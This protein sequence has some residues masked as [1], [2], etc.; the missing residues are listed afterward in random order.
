M[1]FRKYWFGRISGI[2]LFA[3]MMALFAVPASADSVLYPN[4]AGTGEM[5]AASIS[6]PDATADSFI[7]SGASKLTRVTFDAVI[8]RV[9]GSD[10]LESLDWAIGSDAFLS[11]LGSGSFSLF[12]T[13]L[14]PYATFTTQVIG[15]PV[16]YWDFYQEYFD[17]TGVTLDAGT[18]W[19]TLKNAVSTETLPVYWAYNYGQSTAY[20]DDT[21]TPIPSETFEIL[22]DPITTPEPATL[23]LLGTGLFFL[24]GRRRRR[25]H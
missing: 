20:Q 23:T 12:D 1:D 21:N 25:S 10:P 18:Y 24:V 7:L 9:G 16:V 22:G 3:V 4:T 17:L 13:N 14:A 5:D 6:Y 8:Q 19:L 15:G 11:D 2:M